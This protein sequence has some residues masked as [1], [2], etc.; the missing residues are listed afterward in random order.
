MLVLSGI[1][2]APQ[3]IGRLPEGLRIRKVGVISYRPSR[4]A[5]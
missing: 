1:D 4:W 5:P 2:L 3:S